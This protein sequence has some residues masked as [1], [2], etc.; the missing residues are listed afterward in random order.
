MLSIFTRCWRGEAALSEAFWLVFALI[1]MTILG[2]A[3][4]V[5]FHYTHDYD[6]TR[7]MVNTILFPY[8]IFSAVCVWRCEKNASE[9]FIVLSK[10]IVIMSVISFFPISVS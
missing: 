8:L 1:N 6:T 7:R 3:T 2:A 10:A 9:F 4:F 5:F